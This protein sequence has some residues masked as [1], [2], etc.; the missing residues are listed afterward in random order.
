[1]LNNNL[2]LRF[3]KA[4]RNQARQQDKA[5]IYNGKI[6]RHTLANLTSRPIDGCGTPGCMMRQVH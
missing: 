1:M 2:D 6:S 5:T 3:D 4:Y